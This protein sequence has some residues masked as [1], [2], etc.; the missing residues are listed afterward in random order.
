M[1]LA[2]AYFENGENQIERQA[3]LWLE[4]LEEPKIFA[5]D[6]QLRDSPGFWVPVNDADIVSTSSLGKWSILSEKQKNNALS[7]LPESRK[8]NVRFFP[9]AIPDSPLVYLI[10]PSAS[11]TIGTRN[12]LGE[13]CGKVT[14]LGH[15]SSLVQMW[16]ENTPPEPNLVPEEDSPTSFLRVTGKGR[17]ETLEARFKAELR[18]DQGLW[19]GYSPV[20]GD[21]SK[22]PVHGTI[23]DPDMIVLRRTKG[24]RVGLE[25]TLKITSLLRQVVMQKI[26][27]S[28]QDVQVW[29]SGINAAGMDSRSTHVAY[30]PLADVGHSYADGHLLGVGIVFPSVLELE[31]VDK[32][33]HALFTHDTE[34]SSNI[35]E[36]GDADLIQWTLELERRGDRPIALRPE[37]WTGAWAGQPSR[38][39]GTVTPIV[40]DR[41][42]KG[43]HKREQA[44]QTVAEACERIS[45]PRPLSV[46]A[47]STSPILGVQHARSF[48]NMVRKR[49][50]GKCAHTHARIIFDQPVRGPILLGAGRYL[51]YGLCRSIR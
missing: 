22:K 27:G 7:I 48:P 1:A 13:L 51:G 45:L 2:A 39:W 16:L 21:N 37:T 33:I 28:D 12:A 24:I 9:T 11:P 25:S 46:S 36:I 15:S 6:K 49:D 35:L 23:F 20:K 47:S 17:L 18:P 14:Y 41:H 38:E 32:I 44:E 26:S 3:L 29:L 5:S 4:D 40:L 50:G 34:D 19:K 42:G 31:M 43:P 10:W 8:K 30:I